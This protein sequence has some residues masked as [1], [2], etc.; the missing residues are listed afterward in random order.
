MRSKRQKTRPMQSSATRGIAK[1]AKLFLV[2]LGCLTVVLFSVV[3][4]CSTTPIKLQVAQVVSLDCGSE[5]VIDRL[6]LLP[7]EFIAYADNVGIS[8]VRMS[9]KHYEH[10]AEN[11]ART[12]SRFK[13]DATVIRHYRDCIEKFNAQRTE[14]TELHDSNLGD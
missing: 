2:M 4:G 7:I 13:Q 3:T 10:A 14:G 9:V 5:P 12:K 6:V 1:A 11:T 8:W